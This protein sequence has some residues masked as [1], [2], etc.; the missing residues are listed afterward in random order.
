MKP[1]YSIT[2]KALNLSVDIATIL[3]YLEGVQSHAPQA[4]LRKTNRIK[5]IQGSLSIEG[6]TLTIPQITA[7]LDNKRVIGPQRDIAEV[8]NAVKA[9]ENINLF[10][11]TNLKS[12]LKAH[13]HL[14]DKLIVDAGSFRTGGVGILK[15][16]EVSHIAPPA[17]RV[18]L[19]M[20][21]LFS[22]LKN[23]KETHTLIKSC[24]FHYELMFIHPFSDGNG[25]VGR[26]WQTVVLME[27]HSIF[28]FLPIESLIKEKQKQYYNVLEECDSNGNSTA[29]IEFM[30]ALI[31]IS[32]Q[33]FK[34]EVVVE[35]QTADSRLKVAQVEFKDHYFSRKSYILLHKI[36]SSATASRDLKLGIDSSLLESKGD[37][38]RTRYKFK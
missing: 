18:P 29:F 14:L 15:G 38:A 31:L 10:K 6:N 19:L 28:E 23:E 17:S 4:E 9:Y 22:F 2:S 5:T 36:I 11:S 20:D 13:Q 32:L 37:R 26:L 7:I 8:V 3:G 34:S 1:P 27:Y 16:K 25:R 21:D 30:L 24:V 35:N 33:E 12:M